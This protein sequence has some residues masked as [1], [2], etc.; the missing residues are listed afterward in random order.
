MVRIGK[1]NQIIRKAAPADK[2]SK[3]IAKA[4]G[5]QRILITMPNPIPK[6]D[7]SLCQGI[8]KV[9][10]NNPIDN[11]SKSSSTSLKKKRICE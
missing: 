7:R 8:R 9:F 1:N 3:M 10:S 4:I 11:R 5:N 2:Q 6:I